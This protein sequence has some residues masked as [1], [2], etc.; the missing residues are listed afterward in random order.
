ME[1]QIDS[2]T[3]EWVDQKLTRAFQTPGEY[4]PDTELGLHR[5]RHLSAERQ[6]QRRRRTQVA[7]GLAIVAALALTLPPTRVYATRCI[8]ACVE[9]GQF[10]LA[11]L[12][13][14]ERKFS[15]SHD[16]RLE[17]PDFALEDSAGKSIRLSDYKGQVVLLNFWATWCN[18]C[19]I[20]IPWFI[21]FQRTYGSKGFTV[22]GVSLDEDGW[23]PVLPYIGKSG[24][25]YPIALGK[26]DVV[27][28]Y[29]GLDSLPTTLIIDR[30]GRV[31][32]THLGLVSKQVYE[33]GIVAALDE[34][35]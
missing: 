13:P 10:V 4:A 6:L 9:G 14:N 12:R 18:P 31:A 28:A 24:I 3:A 16:Q 11:K 15:I 22:I 1:K 7:F 8:E 21:E 35:R 17:A 27:Q 30:R 32:A 5:L 34:A 23:T 20:E 25:N 33:E 2:K 29:G 19:R 26:N